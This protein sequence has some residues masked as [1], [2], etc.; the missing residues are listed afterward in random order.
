MN[1]LNVW[2]TYDE[3]EIKAVS[4]VLESSNVNYLYGL[5]GKSFEK[6][7][8]KY[9]G[10]KYSI[11]L[12][13]GTLAL[14]SAYI[15]LGLNF[16]D[17]I[18]TTPRT[19]I[20]T[21]STAALIGLKPIFAD[22]DLDSGCIDPSTIE[23]LIT[24]KT[25]AICVVHLSGWPAN[26]FEIKKIAD[27]Y[28]LFV[29]EDCSQAHGAKIA[30]K[31]VGN[32]SDISTWS[33]CQDKIISTGGEGGMITTSNK[34]FKDIIW[35]YKDHGKNYEKFENSKFGNEFK[36]IHDSLG[37]NFRLT[38]M[39]SAIGR[40]QLSKLNL[41]RSKREKNALKIASYIK[42]LKS[43]RVPLPREGITSA[44]YK[45][46]FYLIPNLIKT[47]WSRNRIIKEINN[48]GFKAFSGS[49][50]EIYKEKCF[51]DIKL[52]NFKDLKNAKVLGET[53]IALLI[54]PTITDQQIINY[55]KKVREVIKEASLD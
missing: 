33:F 31:S 42:D 13:N 51:K 35:S 49:C 9:T 7:F 25:K 6:E 26:M 8:S 11:A 24:K 14:T 46:Y 54:H 23:P 39:Q 12:A 29:I 48:S 27:A 17:E 37:S 40:I 41:M 30:E 38:E 18:I 47:S 1:K 43:V 15:S 36:F 55:A 28:N 45:F 3:D 20:A 53:S 50:S 5:E 10:I 44:W 22:V 4:K 32:F 2:P 16:G 52:N 21:S 19:F 34:K